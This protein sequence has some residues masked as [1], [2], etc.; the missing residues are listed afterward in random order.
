MALLFHDLPNSKTRFIEPNCILSFFQSDPL[1][2]KRHAFN[3]KEMAEPTPRDT[4]LKAECPNGRS[5]IVSSD[6]MFDL[7]LGQPSPDAL[8]RDL[9]GVDRWWERMTRPAL[10][11]QPLYLSR[12]RGCQGEFVRVSV[13]RVYQ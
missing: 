13:Y 10:L 7:T 9:S 12:I 5:S 3:L 2:P 11:R 4:V 6:E 1:F 8:H